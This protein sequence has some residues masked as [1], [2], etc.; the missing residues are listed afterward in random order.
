[1]FE[2]VAQV[3]GGAVFGGGVQPAAG[4]EHECDQGSGRVLAGGEGAGQG[5]DGDQV[6]SGPAAAQGADHPGEGGDDRHCGSGGPARI[7][8]RSGAGE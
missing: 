6:D 4:G 3:V 5:E 1:M 2:Q 8:E 7:G